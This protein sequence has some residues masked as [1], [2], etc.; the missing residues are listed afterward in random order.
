MFLIL[1][2]TLISGVAGFSGL[3]GTHH[4]AMRHNWY[5]VGRESDFTMEKPTKINLRNM[6]ITIW[7]DK[8]GS[9]SGIYDVCPHR[10]ASLAKGRIDH[11]TNCV[12]C[13]YHTFK[14]NKKGRMIQTPG[15]ETIRTNT[16]YNLKTD[17]PHFKVTAKN[18]W[19]Y[20]YNNPLFEIDAFHPPSSNTIW[21][22]PEAYDSSFRS[23]FLEKDFAMDART[24]TENSLDILHISEVHSFGNPKRPLPTSCVTERVN[25]GH[26]RVTYEY[27]SG[28]DSMASKLFGI[29]NLIVEN[30]YVLPHYSVAR[31]KFGNFVN[32]IVTSA[33]PKDD[34]TTRLFVK[35]YRN[36]WV[37]GMLPLDLFFDHITENMMKKT[38]SEDK[39][40]IETIYSE[41]KDGNFITKY[42][43]LTKMYREDYESYVITGQ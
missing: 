35:A 43:E 27:E 33:M 8:T 12:V 32:T 42:D 10:G 11:A 4:Q 6:P 7:K 30:E 41:Y 26:V 37:F 36:N 18:G 38:L 21:T 1:V 29:K 40:V 20:V 31:V 3:Y 23:V 25:D 24:V 34:N 13:P 2:I 9:F 22:E 39:E 17:V 28:E 5:I 19:V 16:N 14:F 15:Q